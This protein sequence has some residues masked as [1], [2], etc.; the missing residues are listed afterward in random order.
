MK[1]AAKYNK[2]I[3]F[4]VDIL[5]PDGIGGSNAS[6][7]LLATD[8]ASIIPKQE[9][10]GLAEGQL[11]LAGY[12]D[13]SFRFR[14]DFT[15]GKKLILKHDNDFYVIQSII[16]DRDKEYQLTCIASDH[17][18]EIFELSNPYQPIPI[19]DN[20]GTYPFSLPV[21]LILG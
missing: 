20:R 9:K 14:R 17:I 8:F 6:Y 13:I 16:N 3:E 18:Q 19:V 4:W 12:F 15:I 5:V 7:A 2:T 10:R 1:T 21:Q 11:V